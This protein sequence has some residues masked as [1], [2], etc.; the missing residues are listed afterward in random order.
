MTISISPQQAARIQKAV[1]TGSY[2]SN[3]EVVR[4][5]LRLWEDAQKHREA[6]IARLRRDIDEGLSSGPG[7]KV[8]A[9][10]LLKDFKKRASK[11]G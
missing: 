11:R 2:A 1:D 3:S 10:T 7:R 5:A 9:K 4:D 6:A 8:D